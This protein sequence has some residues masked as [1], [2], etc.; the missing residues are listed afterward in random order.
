MQRESGRDAGWAGAD[1]GNGLGR[2]GV[3]DFLL[4]SSSAEGVLGYG[5]VDR[6]RSEASTSGFTMDDVAS[7]PS[8][9]ERPRHSQSA[10]GFCWKKS[11]SASSLTAA[12]SFSAASFG[13]TGHA[14]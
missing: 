11:A 13:G 2:E 3:H 9:A 6:E 5:G 14:S 10:A 7:G 1:D 8:V 12:C 4:S